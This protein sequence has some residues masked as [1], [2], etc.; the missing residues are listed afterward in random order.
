MDCNLDWEKV[1]SVSIS[2]N[3][4]ALNGSGNISVL[5]EREFV[6][7]SFAQGKICTHQLSTPTINPIAQQDPTPTPTQ[8][9]I[10]QQDPTPTPTPTPTE[11][12][13]CNFPIC[14]KK[15]VYIGSGTEIVIDDNDD[16]WVYGALRIRSLHGAWI[17]TYQDRF[18]C[19]RSNRYNVKCFLY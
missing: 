8:T 19:Q 11:I 12:R 7:N 3:A 5:S 15:D 18:K 14:A 10:A 9:P 1:H 4:V 13:T 16:L 17:R 6:D 2:T